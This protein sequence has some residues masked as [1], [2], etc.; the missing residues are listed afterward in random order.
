METIQVILHIIRHPSSH[1]NICLAIIHVLAVIPGVVV[2]LMP[3]EPTT[4]RPLHS[5]VAGLSE[6]I[7]LVDLRVH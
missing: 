1:I 3:P 7:R 2:D 5:L 4:R 6:K